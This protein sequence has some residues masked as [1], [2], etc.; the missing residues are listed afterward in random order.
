MDQGDDI[1]DV[2]FS[3]ERLE[4]E[5]KHAEELMQNPPAEQFT[6]R[7]HTDDENDSQRLESDSKHS[8]KKRRSTIQYAYASPPPFIKTTKKKKWFSLLETPSKIAIIVFYCFISISLTIMNKWLLTEKNFE[9][10]ITVVLCQNI[11][12][13]VFVWG[14]ILYRFQEEYSKLDMYPTNVDR[15]TFLRIILP[16]AILFSMSIIFINV[17]LML[18]TVTLAAIVQS[19]VPIV[20]FGAYV[21]FGLDK[22]TWQKVGVMTILAAGFGLTVWGEENP[23]IMALIFFISGVTCFVFAIIYIQLLTGTGHWGLP[24][25]LVT[26]YILA[27]GA[28]ISFVAASSLEWHDMF[29]SEFVGSWGT[30]SEF[31]TYILIT[32]AFA[33]GT[34]ISRVIL[35]AVTNAVTYSVV[36]IT[37]TVLVITISQVIFEPDLN[38]VNVIGIFTAVTGIAIYTYLKYEENAKGENFWEQIDETKRVK[39]GFEMDPSPSPFADA[40]RHAGRTSMSSRYSASSTPFHY[41]VFNASMSDSTFNTMSIRGYQESG[42]ERL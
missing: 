11:T 37:E 14:L 28:P 25:L 22:L 30:A 2:S 18:S 40:H 17:G 24:P 8:D 5:E 1:V 6:I 3:S 32:C 31:L 23:N 4:E 7:V 15:K 38:V 34:N 19:T 33:V 12:G 20:M 26:F 21:L 10:P 41:N 13:S 29:H 9:Y 36:G 42:S 27:I 35:I 39:K 16:P